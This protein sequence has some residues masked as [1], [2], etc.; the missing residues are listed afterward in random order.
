MEVLGYFPGKMR[1]F[2]LVLEVDL[3]TQPFSHTPPFERKIKKKDG[4]G[5]SAP[6]QTKSNLKKF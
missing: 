3:K 6:N 2:V 1:G 4:R 5:L